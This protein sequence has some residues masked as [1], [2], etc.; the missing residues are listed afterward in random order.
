MFVKNLTVLINIPKFGVFFHKK[1]I[2]TVDQTHVNK[3]ALT[4][5]CLNEGDIYIAQY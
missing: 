3:Q 4:K 1:R 5:T 2:L